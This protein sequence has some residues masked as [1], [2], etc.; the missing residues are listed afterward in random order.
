MA[1]CAGATGGLVGVAGW[2]SVVVAAWGVVRI[3]GPEA[4]P[5]CRGRVAGVHLGVL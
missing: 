1:P 3:P 5:W 2:W 4:M